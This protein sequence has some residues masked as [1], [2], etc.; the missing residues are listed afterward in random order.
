MVE[1]KGELRVNI[2]KPT[3]LDHV[4][5]AASQARSSQSLSKKVKIDRY[6][7]W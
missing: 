4:R 2:N 3:G 7:V 6:V 1:D 5:Y